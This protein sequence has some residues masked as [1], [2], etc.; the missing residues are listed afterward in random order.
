MRPAIAIL[1]LVAWT[2]L[3]APLAIIAW[4]VLVSLAKLS[5]LVHGND[6]DR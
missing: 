5:Y 3:I 4:F 6:P 1:A 2:L